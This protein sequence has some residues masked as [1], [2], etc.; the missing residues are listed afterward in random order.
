MPIY[1]YRCTSCEALHEVR[2][3]FGVQYDEPCPTCGGTLARQLSATGIVFKGSGFYITDS[4]KS[5]GDGSASTS[6]GSKPAAGEAKSEPKT[7]STSE[8]KPEAK[9]EPKADAKPAK[10]ASDAA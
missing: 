4:R 7:E 9:S 2:H 6:S 8:P 10:P 5:S 3:G 1:D